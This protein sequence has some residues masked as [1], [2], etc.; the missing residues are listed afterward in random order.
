[1]TDLVAPPFVTALSTALT[2]SCATTFG[3]ASMHKEI[4]V[5]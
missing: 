4:S 3:K 2:G 5:Q 1:M